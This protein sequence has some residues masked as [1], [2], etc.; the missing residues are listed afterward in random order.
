MLNRSILAEAGMTMEDLISVTV[1]CP[2]VSLYGK[3][4]AVYRSYFK[5]DF[6]AR[7][8]VGSGP[9][10]FGARFEMQA[11]AVKR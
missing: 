3:F 1:F 2:D 7:A 11:T 5:Q 9:L 10:L 8:F 4:N 6:P